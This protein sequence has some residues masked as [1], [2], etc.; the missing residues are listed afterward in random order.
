[1]TEYIATARKINV[2]TIGYQCSE[3]GCFFVQPVIIQAEA[4]CRD[5]RKSAAHMYA[6]QRA[7]SALV[8]EVENLKHYAEKCEPVLALRR[9]E[10]AGHFVQIHSINKACT[11]CGHKE[12][13][14]SYDAGKSVV[15][16]LDK[17]C[18]P[19]VFDTTS[20]SKEW[21]EKNRK[22][23]IDEITAVRENPQN[24]E[25]AKEKIYEHVG[26]ILQQEQQLQESLDDL[27][28]KRAVFQDKLEKANQELLQVGQG[29]SGALK[30]TV[31]ARKIAN[32]TQKSTKLYQ[33]M[34]DARLTANTKIEN[35]RSKIW[36]QRLI[37]SGCKESPFHETKASNDTLIYMLI[38]NDMNE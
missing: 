24:I 29:V 28:K 2:L 31:L 35:E 13:W 21:L 9:Q 7:A 12:A 6:Q 30:K 38:P 15:S 18:L 10:R 33:N 22:I 11:Q 32:L 4:V 17:R 27:A 34:L 14:Q 16:K 37:I 25:H 3:C 1:M 20:T 19:V 36:K 5:L 23:M 8:Q 26:V